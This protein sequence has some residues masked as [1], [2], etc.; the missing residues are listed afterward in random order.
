MTREEYDYNL[1]LA[2]HGIKGQKWGHRRFQNEDG[3]LTPAG[4][5]RYAIDSAK[6]EY[7][8]AKRADRQ[9]RVAG[10]F[11]LGG[12]GVKGLKDYHNREMEREKTHLNAVD[13]KAKL[14]AAKRGEKGELKAYAKELRKNGLAYSAADRFSGGKSA[15]LYEHL[16]KTKGSDFADRVQQKAQ[17]QILT[18][19]A[20]GV[21]IS[22]GASIAANYLGRR[23]G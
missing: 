6:Q 8:A 21:A 17:T 20:A 5:K 9:A 22:I 15:R 1:Y 19:A 16:S 13:A 3:S 14:A 2:H 11:D 12:A 4:E 10:S 18:T 7:K 23:A